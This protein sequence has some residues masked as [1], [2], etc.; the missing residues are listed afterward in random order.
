VFLCKE[1]GVAED[2]V[3]EWGGCSA[4]VKILAI[5]PKGWVF[6]CQFWQEPLGNIR[7]K[8]LE[9]I[10]KESSLVKMLKKKERY[11]KGKCA[12]CSYKD[13]CGGCRVRAFYVH[14]DLWAEDPACYIS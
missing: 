14:R 8:S 10:L 4:G 12:E 9:T 7:E 5:N 11:L 1:K 13:I 6:P 3:R 2:A